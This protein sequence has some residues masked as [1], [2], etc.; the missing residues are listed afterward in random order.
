MKKSEK[1][2]LFSPFN[3]LKLRENI[4]HPSQKT[5]VLIFNLL[6]GAESRDGATNYNAA[7]GLAESRNY[8]V[9]NQGQLVFDGATGNCYKHNNLKKPLSGI[10]CIAPMYLPKEEKNFN[11]PLTIWIESHGA[12]GWL[13]SG[14]NPTCRLETAAIENFKICMLEL[15]KESKYRIECIFLNA[16]NSATEILGDKGQSN[17]SARLISKVLPN[18][19]VLGFI[20]YNNSKNVRVAEKTGDVYKDKILSLI[21]GS[22]L[23]KNGKAIEYSEETC[24]VSGKEIQPFI[25]QTICTKPDDNTVYM[26]P[27]LPKNKE[28]GEYK[29]HY[30]FVNNKLYYVNDHPAIEEIILKDVE[31]F[32]PLLV[33][34]VVNA[35]AKSKPIVISGEKIKTCILENMENGNHFPSM[36][37]QHYPIQLIPDMPEND[38]TNVYGKK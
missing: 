2:T 16:C 14:K 19:H 36:S 3:S 18:T 27:A 9:I 17:S 13:L 35:A 20:G 12:P 7:K 24:F 26:L 37:N 22:V 6:W 38:R 10:Q 31:K 11:R 32:R 4:F 34:P 29:N 25:L 23:F 30:L 5:P 15:Q 33:K 1:I 8:A 21:N 28:I